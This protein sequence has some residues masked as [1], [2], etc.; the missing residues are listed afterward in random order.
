MA[1]HALQN[2][3]T[4]QIMKPVINTVGVAL[5]IVYH[6]FLPAYCPGIFQ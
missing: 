5:A 2:V 3:R 1:A 4:A 6:T